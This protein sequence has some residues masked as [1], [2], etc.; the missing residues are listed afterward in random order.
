[1][2]IVT[3]NAYFSILLSILHF[4]WG[5]VADPWHNFFCLLVFEAAFTSLFK[6]KSQKE[7]QNSRNQGFSCYF[8]MIIEGSGSEPR[9]GSGSIPLTSGSGSGRPKN[10]WN[11]IR[12]TAVRSRTVQKN[13]KN[14]QKIM[15]V[16]LFLGL[17]C[18]NANYVIETKLSLC[19][20]GNTIF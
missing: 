4:P 17:A 10:M 14:R 8:C 2:W 19:M 11:R 20:T 15:W 6:D 5:S 9:A 16:R 12:N 3:N 18:C 1:M 13:S 7:S